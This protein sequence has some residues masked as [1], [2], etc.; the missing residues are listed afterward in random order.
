MNSALIAHNQ[1]SENTLSHSTNS[2]KEGVQPGQ[3][4]NAPWIE[5]PT[6]KLAYSW[7]YTL[8]R[9]HVVKDTKE[10]FYFCKCVTGSLPTWRP[11]KTRLTIQF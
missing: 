2:L 11:M 6:R 4:N 9:N 10:K 8:L 5:M 7:T 3:V 1:Q